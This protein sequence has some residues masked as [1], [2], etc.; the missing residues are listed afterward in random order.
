MFKGLG[1]NI[2]KSRVEH[3][4]NSEYGF[5]NYETIEGK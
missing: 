3:V 2:D 4:E 1:Q 5:E